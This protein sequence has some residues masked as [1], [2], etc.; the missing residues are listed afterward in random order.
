VN[1]LALVD[2]AVELL[3]LA[4][5]VWV[6]MP[7]DATELVP[8]GPDAAAL[9]RG[10]DEAR[11]EFIG[12]L[13]AAVGAVVLLASTTLEGAVLDDR[14][15]KAV[16]DTNDVAAVV[17]PLVNAEL[18]AAVL[19]DCDTAVLEFDGIPVVE[20]LA[21]FEKVVTVEAVAVEAG[22]LDDGTGWT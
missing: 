15:A 11:L 18:D 21:A 6:P 14:P 4:S 12:L 22:A 9:E 17:V 8:T 1:A 2:R 10:T 19:N 5:A 20:T 3:W 16:L 13:G 7:L